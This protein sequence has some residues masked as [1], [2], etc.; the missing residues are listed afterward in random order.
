MVSSVGR[1]VADLPSRRLVRGFYAPF[2]VAF[3]PRLNL[4][5]SALRKN[6]GLPLCIP[7]YVYV[8]GPFRRGSSL[9]AVSF[10]PPKGSIG[11]LLC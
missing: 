3:S 8:E 2:G 10:T 9:E 6:G 7:E 1:I 5:L 4:D 11:P